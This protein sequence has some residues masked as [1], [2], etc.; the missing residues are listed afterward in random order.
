M[1]YHCAL[2]LDEL[3]LDVHLG[4][5]EAER[6]VTQKVR[7]SVSFHFAA[8]PACAADDDTQQ[9]VC[10]DE[11]S[12][13]MMAYV[14]TRSFRFI[15]YLAHALHAQVREY[16]VMKMPDAADATKIRLCVH[17]VALPVE[18]SVGGARYIVSDA[19]IA[20]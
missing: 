1:T 8:P 19:P 17:K 3:E 20:T 15:E 6:Q 14:A 7:V 9:F 12:R 18:Y 2:M 4:V 13:R 10:Y 16:L 11:V 5:P